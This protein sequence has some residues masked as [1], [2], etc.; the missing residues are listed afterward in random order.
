MTSNQGKKFHIFASIL[1][2]FYYIIKNIK[3]N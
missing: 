2:G 3:K 1:E